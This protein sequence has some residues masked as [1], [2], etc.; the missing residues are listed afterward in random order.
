MQFFL[1]ELA[2]FYEMTGLPK[3]FWAAVA[4]THLAWKPRKPWDR[5]LEYLQ[6][7]PGAPAITWDQFVSFMKRSYASLLPAREARHRYDRLKQ[8]GSVRDF[9]REQVQIVR[10]LEGTPYHPGGSVFDDFMGGLKPDVRRFVEDHAPTGWW[11]N[12]QGLYQK[13]VDFE[14]NGLARARAGSPARADR[15][16]QQ[17]AFNKSESDPQERRY[18][19]KKRS[20]NNFEGGNNNAANK[21]GGKKGNGGGSGGG[22]AGS[23]GGVWI[24]NEEVQ[25]RKAARVCIKCGQEGWQRAAPTRSPLPPL[26][27]TGVREGDPL[28]WL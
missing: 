28:P 26:L 23:S 6:S 10:E 12:I 24:P 9:V 16:N 1:S 13:A 8:T 18:A 5:E 19:G 4:R 15:G 11:T 7:L 20:R 3:V 27:P 14:I 25:A 2:A 21:K 22:G 17:S